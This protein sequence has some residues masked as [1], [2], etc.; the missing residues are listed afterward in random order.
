MNSTTEPCTPSLCAFALEETLR[1]LE[2]AAW[3]D[4][5][6]SSEVYYARDNLRA[7]CADAVRHLNDAEQLRTSLDQLCE[8]MREHTGPDDGTA[9]MLAGALFLLAK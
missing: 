2:T 8:W 7:I 5:V 4:N 1:M 3:Q 9:D 6:P